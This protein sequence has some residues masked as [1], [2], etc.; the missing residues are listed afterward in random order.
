MAHWGINV[1]RLEKTEK[2]VAELEVALNKTYDF[3]KITEAGEDLRPLRGPNFCGMK[4][5]GNSCYVNAVLQCLLA[6]P[7]L[8]LRYAGNAEHFFGTAPEDPAEDFLSM[9]AKVASALHSGAY[10]PAPE[11]APEEERERG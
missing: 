9:M 1:M 11:D 6:A 10:C 7:E 5:L 8:R 4:N 2:T 3:S